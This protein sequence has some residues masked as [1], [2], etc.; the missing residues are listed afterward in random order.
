MICPSP[1]LRFALLLALP[2]VGLAA[3]APRIRTVVS[4]GDSTTA[5]RANVSVY[6]EQLEQRFL[7]APVRFLNRG[8]G[9]NTTAMA[10][11]RF[12]R[13]VLSAKPDIVIV[14]FGM[15]DSMV[16][17]WEKPPAKGPRVAVADYESNL[18]YFVK[19]IQARGGKVV[20]MT[21]NQRRWS[22]SLLKLYSRP[23]YDPNSERGLLAGMDPYNE[24][25]RRVARELGASL[26]DVYALD[27]AWEKASGQSCSQLMLDGMHPNTSGQRLLTD[28]LEPRLRELLACTP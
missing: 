24:A 21:P 12:E 6:T 22:P 26:V 14:Q 13:D 8:V 5:P 3:P 19:A 27:D 18:R 15:N 4:F 17:V 16:D 1:L 20:L 9:G 2:L 10:R 23:P 25:V 7:G 11:Q 28:A